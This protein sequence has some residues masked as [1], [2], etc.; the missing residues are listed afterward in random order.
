MSG[1]GTAT[2]SPD[3]AGMTANDGVVVRHDTPDWVAEDEDKMFR[4]ARLKD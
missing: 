1:P 4:E 3:H 2:S